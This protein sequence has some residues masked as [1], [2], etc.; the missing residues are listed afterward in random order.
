MLANRTG[1]QARRL[2]AG[3]GGPDLGRRGHLRLIRRGDR[4]PLSFVVPE[5]ERAIFRDRS[6]ERAAVLLVLYRR[7]RTAALLDEIVRRIGPVVVT[8]VVRRAVRLVRTALH[9]DV[10]GAA[11][12]HA[13]LR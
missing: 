7:R 1:R 12:L 3:A 4:E 6:A 2:D 10:D 9:H 8:E 5:E 13:E 11:P